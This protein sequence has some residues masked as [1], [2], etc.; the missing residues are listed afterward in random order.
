[1]ISALRPEISARLFD[2]SSSLTVKWAQHQVLY[3]VAKRPADEKLHRQIVDA[4]RVCLIVEALRIDP[5]LRKNITYG[6]RRRL[7][8][9]PLVR[10]GRLDDGIRQQMPH[11]RVSSRSVCGA[12]S[13]GWTGSA[14]VIVVVASSMSS[15]PILCPISQGSVRSKS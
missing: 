11:K 12:R 10:P 7:E 5:T 1:M 14:V 15:S 2:A 9:L 4:L 3:V 13:F 8:P 6:S